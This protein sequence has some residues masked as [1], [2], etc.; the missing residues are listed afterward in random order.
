MATNGSMC[1]D[2]K[3]KRSRVVVAA[4]ESSKSKKVAD[5]SKSP[6]LSDD[7]EFQS[8]APTQDQ[9]IEELKGEIE[10]LQARVRDLEKQVDEKAELETEVE[11]LK[12]QVDELTGS[13]ES[14]EDLNQV[15]T[16]K[17][18]QHNDELQE[19]RKVLIQEIGEIGE[20]SCTATELLEIGES[21]SNS[22][23][24]VGI[25]RMGELHSKPF[26]D[27]LKDICSSSSEDRFSDQSVL[28][29]NFWEQML[30]DPLWHP[31]KV[32]LVDGKHRELLDEEDKLLKGLKNAW[33][34]EAYSTV[35]NALL[36]LNEYNPNGRYPV[37][38]LWNFEE[39]RRATV[40][41]GVAALAHHLRMYHPNG[42]HPLQELWNFEGLFH[43]TN[44]TSMGRNS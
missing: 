38:E 22:Q 37:Q 16:V 43:P 5:R 9:Q 6:R 21:S 19:A 7:E 18:F 17:E 14:L 23:C 10:K 41:E 27:A 44:T 28:L 33:G 13:V 34:K 31:F 20:S 30:K 26:C 25:K 12:E 3:K 11:I 36:E 40:N 4:D 24:L 1:L 32:A 15:L 42:R 35:V 29:C 8:A 39:N 2:E